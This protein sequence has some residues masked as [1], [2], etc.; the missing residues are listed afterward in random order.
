[1]IDT[2]LEL[3]PE[4]VITLQHFTAPAWFA[5]E[6]GWLSAKAVDR[7]QSFVTVATQILG[8]VNWIAT[9]NEPNMQAMT[10][11]S[12]EAWQSGRFSQWQSSTVGGEAQRERITAN[13]PVPEPRIGQRMVELHRGAH[14]LHVG[15]RAH[16][17]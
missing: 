7:F 13:L 8:G 3:G 4:P 11:M 2:A 12:Q 14:T 9:M 15:S 17:Q 10:V 16:R 5:E 6:G 1:M